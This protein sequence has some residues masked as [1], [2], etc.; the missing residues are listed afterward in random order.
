MLRPVAVLLLAFLLPAAAPKS[1]DTPELSYTADGQMIYPV[2][3]RQ[4]IYLTSGL[5]MSYVPQLAGAG[6]PM[7]DNVFVNPTAWEAFQKTGTWPDK[8]VLVLEV[9][10]ADSNVSIDHHGQSQTSELMGVE[11]HV[12]DARLPGGWGFFEFDN[13]KSAKITER[14]A[15]C[16]TCH[17]SHAAV[18][19]TFV[20]FYPTLIGIAKDKKTLSAEY[21]KEK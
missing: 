6:H 11:A 10:G 8:T 17:E 12:K 9:R 19:T 7:F 16:Y 14:P 18:D 3:Y 15:T 5:G 1:A 4:W 20:Q 13:Q 2:N 21:L